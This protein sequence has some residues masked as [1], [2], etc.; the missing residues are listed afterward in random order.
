MKVNN[1]GVQ[2][3]ANGLAVGIENTVNSILKLEKELKTLIEKFS[4]DST[5]LESL[6]KSY[7]IEIPKFI[8][9]T[10]AMTVNEFISIM[11][12]RFGDKQ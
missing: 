12:K 4:L 11:D 5:T 6:G 3:I 7:E 10:E 8:T 1:E 2:K 9:C